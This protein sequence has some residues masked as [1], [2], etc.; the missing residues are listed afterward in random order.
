MCSVP[1][2][3]LP[4]I[5]VDVPVSSSSQSSIVWCWASRSRPRSPVPSSRAANS[6]HVSTWAQ[7]MC[8]LR[9]AFIV[10]TNYDI[11]YSFHCH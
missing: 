2:L 7:G 5:W 1:T 4:G 10:R 8:F 3:F 11:L 6:G 9:L